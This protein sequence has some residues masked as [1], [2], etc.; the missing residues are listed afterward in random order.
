[1]NKFSHITEDG[2]IK[3]VD[4]SNKEVIKRTAIAVG[5]IYLK[6]ETI[7]L[8]KEKLLKKVMF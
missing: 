2:N 1:M 8:L 4:I 6:S 5:R 3:M 7:E